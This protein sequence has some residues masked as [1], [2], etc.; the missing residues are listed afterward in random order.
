MS[1]I[2]EKHNDEDGF[3]YMTYNSEDILCEAK[4]SLCIADSLMLEYPSGAS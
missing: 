4:T 2:Y 3:L 1:D